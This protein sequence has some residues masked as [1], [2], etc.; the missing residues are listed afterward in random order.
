MDQEVVECYLK[1]GEIARR[2]RERARK[3]LVEG[4]GWLE[5]TE[6]VEQ[7]IKDLGGGWAFPLNVSAND[8]AAHD[9]ARPGD[10]RLFKQGDVIKV[11]LGVHVEGCIADTAFPALQDGTAI[12]VSGY[13]TYNQHH[14]YWYLDITNAVEWEH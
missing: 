3:W 10:E 8:A 9:A 12:K 11:D 2:V 5:F 13:M 4:A 7:K 14:G 6:N 1:A